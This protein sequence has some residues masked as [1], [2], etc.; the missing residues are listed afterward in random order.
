[1]LSAVDDSLT[2][3]MTTET[4]DTTKVLSQVAGN[5][6]LESV[7]NQI[8]SGTLTAKGDDFFMSLVTHLATALNVPYAVVTEAKG[9]RLDILAFWRDGK[10][11][12]QGCYGLQDTP[13][14][15]VLE[16]GSYHCA[17]NVQETFP[18]DEILVDLEAESYYG[19]SLKDADGKPMGNLYVLDREPMFDISVLEG[20]LQIFSIRAA[21]ELQ[22]QQSIQAIQQLSDDNARLYHNEQENSQKLAVAH[23]ELTQALTE[24]EAANERLEQRVAERTQ[25]LNEAKVTAESANQAKSD[26]LANMS[27]ELRTPLNGILGYAQILN[28][29][30]ELKEGNK[31]GVEIIYQ[32]GTHLLT[33]INDVL[34]LSKIEAR[35]LD[36]LPKAVHLPSLLQGVIEICRIRAEQKG[37]EFV[38][39][40]DD[41]LPQGICVDEK[42]L[43]QVLINLIGNAVKFTEQG[44]VTLKVSVVDDA[45]A[46]AGDPSRI[47]LRFQVED[48]G[49]GIA[50]EHL[51][52]LFKAFE[53]VGDRTR[54]AAGTGLGLAISQKIVTL[55]GGQ[56][57]V[58][59]QLNIGSRFYFD[60]SF[61]V[62]ADWAKQSLQSKWKN[63]TGYQGEQQHVLVVDDR[64][65]N[66]T[67]VEKLLEPLGFQ[68]SQAENGQQGLEKMAALQPDLVITDLAMPVMDGFDM[69]KAIRQTA[70]LQHHKVIVSSASVAQLDQQM[71]TEAGG[72]TFLAKPVDASDL[73]STVAQMLELTWCYEPEEGAVDNAEP[74]TAPTGDK[75]I[76][77]LV[78]PPLD[79]VRSLLTQAQAGQLRKL[80][81]ALKALTETDHSYTR[82]AAPMM[83]AIKQ[84]RS[85]EV[86]RLLA[87]YLAEDEKN[88]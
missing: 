72:D 78:I 21:A 25:E 29:S 69:L 86:E 53:Q 77:P 50:P 34:D 41:G 46:V 49:V 35:K 40:F 6:A 1:M 71:A 84:Y 15:H 63:I 23:Q 20:V 68:I 85:E 80:G 43:R 58:E 56:I 28:Q 36:L 79:V 22:Q 44:A 26:F 8:F 59:S 2:P 9:D 10:L 32:C 81:Q 3:T 27:H 13:C 19:V 55:M 48:T 16:E 39:S 4:E 64:W 61:P 65:E 51:T 14:W 33:L 47:C 75:V 76:P 52:K 82:F 17:R 12:P 87:Q 42:R 62:A 30:R 57:K 18:L 73:F 66:R 7:L 45:S 60:L 37:I 11:E 54:Q 5:K 88:D 74:S 38:D 83:D 31:K 24:K 70:E 67:V